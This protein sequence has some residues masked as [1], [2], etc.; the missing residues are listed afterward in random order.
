[1]YSLLV[2]YEAYEVCMLHVLQ[3]LVTLSSSI[4]CNLRPSKY[5]HGSAEVRGATTRSVYLDRHVYK[6]ALWPVYWRYG[7][8][9]S[10][11]A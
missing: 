11:R 7:S 1:M 5:V 3:L 6:T 8:S 10:M 4:S 2:A 9:P